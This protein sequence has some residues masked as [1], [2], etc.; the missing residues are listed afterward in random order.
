MYGA[1]GR[2]FEG[3]WA[4][5]TGA[6]SGIGR[7]LAL[8]LAEGGAR[9][10]LS[11]RDGARL[12]QVAAEVG[13]EGRILAADLTD[14]GAVARLAADVGALTEALDLLVHSAGVVTL[15]PVGET[16]AADLDLNWQVNLRAP[17]L[18]T[19]ALLPRVRAARG[20]VAFVNSGAGLAANPGWGAY[21]ASKHGLKALAD[22]LRAEVRGDGVRVLSVYPGRTASPMQAAVKAHEGAPYQPERLIQP[23]DVSRMTLQALALP[24]TAHVVD[25]NIRG[26]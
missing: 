4:L 19:T 11:G 6:S 17:F 22:A 25:V 15:G 26:A 14:P 8:G 9:V 10:I 23:E 24:R 20:Q 21:A 13:P 7:A 12:A 1:G 18:L 3:R 16:T 5:V 2:P